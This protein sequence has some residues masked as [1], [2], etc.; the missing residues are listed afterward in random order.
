MIALSSI[1]VGK[2][3]ND[4]LDFINNLVAGKEKITI[5]HTR[6][7]EQNIDPYFKNTKPSNEILNSIRIRLQ[8]NG[9]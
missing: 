2:K 4:I 6:F 5:E 1:K 3:W 9:R 7:I 8:Q